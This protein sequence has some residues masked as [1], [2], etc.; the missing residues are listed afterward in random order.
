MADNVERIYTETPLI[1]E[2]VYQVKGMIMEGIVL[3]DIEEANKNETLNSIRQS[4]KYADIIEGKDRFELWEY[5]YNT[6]IKLPSITKEMAVM[7][8]MN[9]ALID[10]KSKPLLL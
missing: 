7:Y 3:K 10:E 4:D 2:I 8:A 1:D 9:N 5:D 6:I